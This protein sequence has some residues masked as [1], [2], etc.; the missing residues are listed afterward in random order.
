LIGY[1][2]NLGGKGRMRRRVFIAGLVAASLP[3][4]AFAQQQSLPIVGFLHSGS[5]GPNAHL[6]AAF[7][8]GLREAGFEE[9]RNVAI[10]Y[11]WAEG[12]YD[13]L[14]SLASDLISRG[15]VVLYTA[16]GSVAAIEA[17]KAAKAI[18][19]VFVM[20]SDPVRVGLVT[21]LNRP[22]G[23]ATGVTLIT[24]GLEAKRLELLRQLV[25]SADPIAA[26][27]NP[28]NPNAEDV[29]N[30]VQAAANSLGLEVK[31][32][33]AASDTQ[34]ESILAALPELRVKGILVGND[35]YFLSRRDKII[36]R[37]AEI[38]MPAIYQSREFPASGGLASYGSN[39][40]EM[41]R[42]SGTYVGRA[43]KGEK[44]AEMPVQQ[45][46]AFEL[47]F[48]LKTAR[49]LGLAIP[50]TL[51]ATADEVLE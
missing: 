42:K 1:D 23:N 15:A 47:V 12:K 29:A 38:S 24:G 35:P 37:M 7:Q 14:P 19:I 36:A 21:S 48:N 22:G 45:P 16:G 39:L 43:L 26:L 13:R 27:I 33:H 4:I 6:V 20:G 44:L 31:L 40:A 28:D 5:S 49:A 17:R 2:A 9:G 11:R 30:D 25:P 50:Q 46:T 41:Y 18:P 8:H 34:L 51:L 10:E 32:L 3:R